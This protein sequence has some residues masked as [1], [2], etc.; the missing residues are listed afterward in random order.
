V[1]KILVIEDDTATRS[2]FL[3][4]LRFEGFYAIGAENGKL[5]IQQAQ[6]QLPDLIICDIM[7]P[8]FNGYEVLTALRQNP[9]TAYIPLIFV[10][11]KDD[12][13]DL[14]QATL[15][16][17]DG[18]LVK[19]CRGDELL[20]AISTRLAKQA[21]LL[22]WCSTECQ[23]DSESPADTAIPSSPESIFPQCPQMTEI[24]YFIEK[25]YHQ[26]I[27]LCDVAQAFGYSP[28]YLTSLVRQHTGESIYRWIVK[29]RM[30]QALFLLQETN[31]PINQIAEAVGYRD[32]GH[33]SR[34]FRQFY[35]TTPQAWRGAYGTK[36]N[37]QPLK[38][39]VR[40][41]SL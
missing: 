35:G 22:E 34:H 17:A 4:Y 12:P 36:L 18:Y 31:Q 40:E 26:P 41:S 28:A 6:E 14:R 9:I 25:N 39:R 32:A 29:R 24:F 11:C 3:S 2:F 23:R 15:L 21:A 5:G 1:K 19:P 20:A 30:A 38:K 8:D 37:A 27:T 16:G 10:S 33:F 13:P 7:M